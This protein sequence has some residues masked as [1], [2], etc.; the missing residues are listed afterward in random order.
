MKTIKV[1]Q[2]VLKLIPVKS[3]KAENLN[4][5][6]TQIL[7]NWCDN[8]LESLWDELSLQEILNIYRVSGKWVNWECWFEEEPELAIKGLNSAVKREHCIKSDR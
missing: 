3:E 4:R 2:M 1:D 8:Q 5:E 7:M 6:E